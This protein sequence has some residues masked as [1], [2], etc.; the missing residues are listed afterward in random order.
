MNLIQRFVLSLS[1][2]VPIASVYADS[3]GVIGDTFPIAEMSF[4]SFIEL[5]LNELALHGE[6]DKINEDMARTAQAH[7]NRPTP[8]GL[9]RAM[10]TNEHLY[11]P[12]AWINEDILDAQGRIVV[13]AGTHIN[14]LEKLPQYEP[15][16]LFF[17]GDDDAQVRWAKN[18]LTKNS[19][20]K[21]ILTGGAVGGM[22]RVLQHE[23]FFD[24]MGR[25]S[26]QLGINQVPAIVSRRNNKLAILEVAIKED[27][28]V[29]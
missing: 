18:Q 4:L 15:Y 17:N 13:A 27:G 20:A 19:D 24:Q 9:T 10:V 3:L 26:H 11:T 7:A 6:L 12:E 8:V 28:D 23:I 29:R 1:F 16:W 2:F 22:E 5:R 14:A 25:I 21:I